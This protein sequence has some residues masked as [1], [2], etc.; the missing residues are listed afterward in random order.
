M[1]FDVPHCKQA[2]NG[3]CI[4]EC[5]VLKDKKH[6]SLKKTL[7]SHKSLIKTIQFY[8]YHKLSICEYLTPKH[9]PI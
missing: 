1:P 8:C 2:S 7:L 3:E 4:V 5:I 9:Q 6:K